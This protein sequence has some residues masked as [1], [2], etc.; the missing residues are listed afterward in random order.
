MP[1]SRE[2]TGVLVSTLILNA[3]G[4]VMIYSASAVFADKFYDNSFY[5][6]SK[7]LIFLFIG[8]VSLLAV[9][10]LD[11]NWVQKH[12]RLILLLSI[13][14]LLFVYLPVIGKSGGGARRWIRL[15]SFNF[16]PVEFAK[17]AVAVYLA[18][19]LTR[20]MKW[21]QLGSLNVFIPPSLLLGVIFALVIFQPDLGSVVFLFLLSAILFFVS[22]IRMRYVIGTFLLSLPVFAFAILQAPYR[23]ARVVTF[24]NPWKDP[25]GSGFQIIQS[26]LAFGLGGM[27]GVGLGESVQKL[28]YLPQSYT[29]FIYSIIGEE[30]G[31]AGTLFVLATFV[32]L[33]V[34]GLKIALR[35]ENPFR[36]LLAFA[37]VILISL[38]A[39][40]NMLVTTGM[41]PT[42]GLPLPFIS[43]GGSSLIC[44]M[45]AIGILLAIDREQL[46]ESNA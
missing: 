6:L 13:L 32:F 35:S 17:I 24:L 33:A 42:K 9:A 12:S 45:A 26:F 2:G 40:I 21:I 19:Y 38:Q 25:L 34:Q 36:Q 10:S 3:V 7:Q 20:K 22:G 4:T 39:I 23:M 14:L 18:D 15:A 11:L 28:F 46:R 27:T 37:V 8:F 31:L 44:N 41:I 29:D 1:L 16:Q 43:Y 5:F 30:L